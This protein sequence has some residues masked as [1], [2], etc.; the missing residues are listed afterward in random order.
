[1]SDQRRQLQARL[2]RLAG[3]HRQASGLGQ[4]FL[5]ALIDEGKAASVRRSIT[6]DPQAL[7]MWTKVEEA[8]VEALEPAPAV[9]PALKSFA[10]ILTQD[11]AETVQGMVALMRKI[12]KGGR[13]G[14]GRLGKELLFKQIDRKKVFAFQRNLDQEQQELLR[15]VQIAFLEAL[16]PKPGVEESINRFSNLLSANNPDPARIRNDLG[17]LADQLGLST[18][19]FL[20]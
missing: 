6:N 18:R 20:F 8:L 3:Q 15:E 5:H 4:Q 7:A 12:P 1:M 13:G 17:K 14:N 11:P 9:G 16:D 10:E 2:A 19:G